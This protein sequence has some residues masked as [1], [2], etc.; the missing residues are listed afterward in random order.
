MSLVYFTSRNCGL[1]NVLFLTSKESVHLLQ[2]GIK[3]NLQVHRTSLV[4]NPWKIAEWILLLDIE[5]E[6]FISALC[7]LKSV[8]LCIALQ[9]IQYFNISFWFLL[10]YLKKTYSFNSSN[11]AY[12]QNYDTRNPWTQLAAMNLTDRELNTHYYFKGTISNQTDQNRIYR[13]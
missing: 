8:K 11:Y 4:F 13:T 7:K 12:I 1:Q 3:V 6:R 9:L 5:N 2:K 10:L